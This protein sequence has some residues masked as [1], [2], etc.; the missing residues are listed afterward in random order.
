MTL[1]HYYEP[2][3]QISKNDDSFYASTVSEIID[4]DRQMDKVAA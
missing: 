3:F 2:Q 4:Y 1:C